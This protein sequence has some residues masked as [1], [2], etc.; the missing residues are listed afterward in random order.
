MSKYTKPPTSRTTRGQGRKGEDRPR[1][2]FV[3]HTAALGGAELYVSD[4]AE[5][6]KATAAA[7]LFQDGPLRPRLEDRG[8]PVHLVEGPAALHNVR[9][10]SSLRRAVAAVPALVKV[11]MAIARHARSYDLVFANSQKAMICAGPAAAWTRTPLVWCLHDLLTEDHF[12]RLNRWVA[13]R[14]ANLFASG[15]L[16]NSEATRAAFIE[17][18]GDGSR[19]ALAY[20]GIDPAP[21]DEAV[22]EPDALRRDLGIP[23]DAPMLGVF[24]RLA[25]WKGQHVAVEAVD[26]LP[27]AHL[28]L[29]GDA[30]F[31]EDAYEQ[32]LRSMAA[33]RAVTDRV[34]LLGF[35][36]DIPRLMK[37]VN[38]VLHTSTSA[39]PFGRVI[40]EG[41]M[42]GTP[43][44][45]TKG[46]GPDEI[47]DDRQTGRLVPAGDPKALAHAV[48]H[49]L[50][51]RDD[52]LVERARQEAEVR[53]SRVAMLRDV[54]RHL[55]DVLAK[56]RPAPS[57]G[58]HA[59]RLPDPH[60]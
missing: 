12:S 27:G 30:M 24:S 39:E 38:V 21:F 25:P 57:A 33:R 53:F 15:V 7:L 2:L 23:A 43:V 17:A 1:I 31:G 35:R 46:G 3:D 37:A 48:D 18:G 54:D 55:R 16:V 26:H 49:V 22:G 10:G 34:H 45:A 19:T 42:A 50:T 14:W 20:N 58:K 36:T 59:P 56:N 52:D 13:T 40:I 4:V 41:M 28:L 51:A 60:R 8:I 11:S 44:V 47:I 6:Y 32:H 5:A 29:V 9:K